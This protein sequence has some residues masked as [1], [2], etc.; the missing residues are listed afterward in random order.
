[1]IYKKAFGIKNFSDINFDF[2]EAQ[3]EGRWPMK[4]FGTMHYRFGGGGFASAQRVD[5][6]DFKHFF[7]NFLTQGETDLLGFFT[8]KYYTH[9]T[10][11][12]FAEAHIEHHF[13]GFFF[14]KIP[15][16]RKLKLEE[17]IGFHFL[18][19]PTRKQYFQLDLGIENILKIFR[20]DF[21]TG[22]GSTKGEYY[23]GGRVGMA[24]D[25]RR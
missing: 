8:I 3:V 11:R 22:F 12:Y 17:V 10:N 23:F 4:L 15:G 20:V 18:Y 9:S 19:T 14:N 7:G 25:L 16:F 2:L 24:L 6:N 13:D 5:Y 1:L 21:V